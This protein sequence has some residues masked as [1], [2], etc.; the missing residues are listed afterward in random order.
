MPQK[1]TCLLVDSE[2]T[3]AYRVAFNTSNMKDKTVR[4]EASRLLKNPGVAAAVE[5]LR[6][7]RDAENH[8]LWRSKE[9]RVWEMV[10]SVIEAD[11]V[12][13]RSKIKALTLAASMLGMV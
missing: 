6:A 8:M 4:D 12:S 1:H 13:P 5:A 9:D 2:R 7:K 10:W 11:H 3:D